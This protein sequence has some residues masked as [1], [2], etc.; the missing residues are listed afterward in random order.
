[1]MKTKENSL[2]PLIFWE[3]MYL[4]NNFTE[5]TIMFNVLKIMYDILLMKIWQPCI[6]LS[7]GLAGAVL[8]HLSSTN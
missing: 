3:T 4:Y 6:T 2:I 1:M 7:A 8:A 5:N